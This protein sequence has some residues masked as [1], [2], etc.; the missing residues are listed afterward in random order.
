[1]ATA[2]V[3]RIKAAQNQLVQLCGGIDGVL[4]ISDSFARSTVGRWNNLD[5]PTLMP[6]SAVMTLEAHCGVPLVT[7]AL[8]EI[9]GRRLAEP[10]PGAAADACVLAAHA[11]AIMQ[12]GELMRA[13]AMAFSDGR[14]TPAEARAIDAAGAQ[15]EQAVAALRKALAGVKAEGGATLS[16]VG[17]GA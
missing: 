6:L 3:H 9:A 15:M 8:A 5:D 10:E 14:V 16:V 11:E 12:A 17:R 1:M 13:G 7:K 4:D 2:R